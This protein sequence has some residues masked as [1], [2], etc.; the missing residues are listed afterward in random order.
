MDADGE[1]PVRLT[2]SAEQDTQP[3]WSPCLDYFN[4]R[5]HATIRTPLGR[6]HGIPREARAARV[7]GR[8]IGALQFQVQQGVGW[9]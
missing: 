5:D 4:F 3:S 9:W 2:D 1:N 7:S 8:C 6:W